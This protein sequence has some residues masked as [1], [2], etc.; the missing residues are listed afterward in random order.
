MQL[1]WRDES[2]KLMLVTPL[3]ANS[4][5]TDHNQNNRD[6][7]PS[8]VS[9]YARDLVAGRWPVTHQ[10]I[11]FDWNGALVDGQH[12]LSAIVRTG[13]SATLY[14]TTGLDP[15]V[16]VVVDVHSKRTVDDAMT[17]AGW[18]TEYGRLPRNS[19]A[20]MWSRMMYGVG[21]TKGKETRHELLE[22]AKRYHD[23]GDWSLNEFSQY[24]RSRYVMTATT[25]AAVARA[26]YHISDHYRL[27]EFVAVLST[28]IMRSPEDS[29]AVYWRN[30]ITQG[31]HRGGNSNF[32]GELYGK[33]CR[34]IQSFCSRSVITKFYAPAEEP[35]PLPAR[36]SQ[37]TRLVDRMVGNAG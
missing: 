20:G 12:R 15:L 3:M 16:R 11:A 9:Q 1:N 7:K 24:P 29:S 2:S 28:G 21:Q 30:A 36:P 22:F 4:W 37:T 31:R 25:M 35:F 8:V 6:I 19:I 23:A 17:L 34:A 14:V 18:K 13:C 26:Y 33:T 32:A 10:G 5:L 27:A